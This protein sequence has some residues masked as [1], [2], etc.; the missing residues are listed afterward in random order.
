[1]VGQR[2]GLGRISRWMDPRGDGELP[3]ADVCGQQATSG[4]EIEK[5]ARSLSERADDKDPRRVIDARFS[6]A[7]E[8]RVATAVIEGSGCVWDSDL[9]QRTMGDSHAPRNAIGTERRRS[10]RTV[11]G[12]AK[13]GTHRASLCAAVHG[14]FST[15]D[16]ETDD[17]CNG[18]GGNAFDGLVFRSVGALDRHSAL[19]RGVSGETSRAGISRD[20]QAS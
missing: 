3:G 10:G 14:R 6:W 7:A 5:L 19:F 17:A 11:S 20:R 1:M 16:R 9:W 13:N 8:L 15:G 18:S 4:S 12:F 2:G